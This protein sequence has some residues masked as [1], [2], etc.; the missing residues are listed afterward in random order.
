MGYNF[1]RFLF[2]VKRIMN[3]HRKYMFNFLTFISRMYLLILQ[4]IFL[5]FDKFSCLDNALFPSEQTVQVSLY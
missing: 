2:G 1:K 3:L 4:Q 5:I